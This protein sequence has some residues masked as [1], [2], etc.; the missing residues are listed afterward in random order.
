MF[1]QWDDHETV[2][3]WYPGEVLDDPRYTTT[4]VDVLAARAKRAFH[5]YMPVRE[6]R[7]EEGRIYRMVPHGPSLDIFFLDMRT[8]RGPNTANDQPAPG[9]DTDLLGQRQLRWLKRAL[10]ASRATWKVIASDMPLGLVVPDGSAFEAVANADDG[11]A[12]GREHELADLLRFIAGNGVVNVVWLTADVHY[13]AAHHYHPER[14]AFQDF[15]PFWE[16]V[17]GPLHA[18][19]FGPNALDGTFGPR[20][21]FQ[22]AADRPNQPPSDGL[23]FFGHVSIDGATDV[24]TVMLKDLTGATLFAVDL[25][26]QR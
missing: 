10:R 7:A 5:E 8:Y 24:M 20:V 11:A 13:T 6:Q 9:P 1:A 23:Q 22:R 4:D 18:G 19:T 12:L 21:V 25:E 14:A 2:N 16:F 17:S 3:N 15:A 26:P